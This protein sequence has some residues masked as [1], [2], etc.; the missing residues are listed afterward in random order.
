[1]QDRRSRKSRTA[2]MEI[3]SMKEA[4]EMESRVEQSESHASQTTDTV[5]A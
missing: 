4:G 5:K 2:S 1:M 3:E